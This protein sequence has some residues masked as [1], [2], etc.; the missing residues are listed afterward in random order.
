[1]S[2]LIIPLA[3]TVIAKINNVPGAGQQYVFQDN[4]QINK[5]NIRLWAISAYSETQ[6]IKDQ[7][8]NTLV[9]ATGILGINFTLV[10]ANNLQFVQNMPVYD[11]I[12]SFN[13]G[14]WIRFNGVRLNLTKCF[15]QLQ[16][17]A[18]ISQNEV[19]LFNLI[20]SMING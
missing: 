8:G 4:P 18:S 20:Y 13:S 17:N 14:Q 6:V 12:R 5:A 2:D 1:M 9:D 10:D 11:A 3:Q 19:V 15:I 7:A 16:S